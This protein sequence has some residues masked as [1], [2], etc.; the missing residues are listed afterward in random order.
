MTD[1][2]Y[3]VAGIGIGRAG[4]GRTR[5]YAIH[6]LC[7]V[8]AVA[9]SDPPN[10]ELAA[11]R[12]G[13]PGYADCVELFE[14]HQVDIAVASLP[15]RANHA[16]VMAAAAA[17]V[18]AI[19]TE[20]PLT[21]QLSQADDMVEACRS[22]GIQFAAGLLS[23]N[24]LNHWTAQEM[25]EAGAIGEVRRIN[26]YDS[27][28][29]GGCHGINLARHFAGD[30][31]VDH[32][33][34]WTKGDAASDYEDAHTGREHDQGFQALG[35]YIRFANGV[36]MFSSYE[37]VP[38]RGFEVIGTR[39]ILYKKG[40]TDLKLHILKAPDD[41][42][43]AAFEDFE[44]V[45]VPDV[46]PPLRDG[47]HRYD[48]DGWAELTDGM[49]RSTAAVVEAL[50]TGADIKLTTGADL[51]AALEVCIALRESARRGSVPV[52]LP[53]AD[54]N[55]VMYPQNSRWNYKKEQMGHEA[56]M[57]ALAQQRREG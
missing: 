30:P 47:G 33:I 42:E 4:T 52:E 17:G 15:V 2:K 5:A 10:L 22:R 1:A 9:E 12:F 32:V 23:M 27:N 7:E 14:K 16:V 8:V 21:A 20:K 34:G 24:R 29:Q 57:E 43:Q 26:N 44:A 13:V 39:G 40:T 25:I 55:L 6:P 56:Y 49:V 46:E 53:L 54:R 31:R 11:S 45:D 50:E 36:E 3:K 35:G 41:A 37:P 51:Q 38:W 28:T 19:V 48:E 18:K